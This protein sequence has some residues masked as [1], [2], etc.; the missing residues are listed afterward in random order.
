M[1]S[2]GLKTGIRVLLHKYL[3]DKITINAIN[4]TRS[5]EMLTAKYG[6]C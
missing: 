1:H 5:I 2:E 4:T 3:L 6:L